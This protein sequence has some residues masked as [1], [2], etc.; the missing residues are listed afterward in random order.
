MTRLLTISSYLGIALFLMLCSDSLVTEAAT[1]SYGNETDRL[2]L[3]H[4]K[5]GISEDPLGALRSWNDTAHFCDWDGVACDRQRQRVTALNLTSLQLTGSISPHVTNLTYLMEL[6]LSHNGFQGMLPQEIGRLSHLQHLDLL[7]NHVTGEIPTG[8]SNCKDL[9][10]LRLRFNHFTGGIPSEVSFLP[11]LQVL[12]LFSNNLTGTIPPSLGNLSSLIHLSVAI[13][14]IEGSFPA[15]IG[16]LSNLKRLGFHGNYISGTIPSE[17]LNLSSLELFLFAQNNLHGSLPSDVGVAL[18]KLQQF[19]GGLNQFTGPIPASL[20][21]ASDLQVFD[22]AINQLSGP[23]PVTFGALHRLVRLNFGSNNLEV[24]KDDGM[25]FITTL[26]NCSSLEVFAFDSNLLSGVLPHS[27]VNLSSHLNILALGTNQLSG[28]FPIGIEKYV[29]LSL[30]SL[31]SNFFTGQIPM[32]LGRFHL[33]EMLLLYGNEFFGQIPSSLGNLTQLSILNLAGNNFTGS[34]PPTLGNCQGLQV[35]DL[36]N[37]KLNGTVPASIL[38]ISSLSISLNLSKN[39]LTGALPDEVQNLQSLGKLDVS[40]NKLSGKI[41]TALGRCIGLESLN[42]GGNYFEGT[43]PLFLSALSGIRDL[44]LSANNLSGPI[45]EFLVKLSSLRNLNL[46]FNSLEGEVPTKGVFGNAS[47]FSIVGNHNLCGGI[48]SLHLPA[49]SAQTYPKHHNRAAEASILAIASTALLLLL[50]ASYFSARHLL[51]RSKRKKV[52]AVSCPATGP[53]HVSYAE[54]LGAAS[55]FSLSKLVGEGSYGSVYKAE[56]ICNEGIVAVKVFRTEGQAHVLDI[57]R[58]ECEAMKNIRHRNLVKIITSCSSVDFRGRDFKA[59]VYEHMPNGNLD[60]WLHPV[61]S[62]RKLMLTERLNIAIDVASALE[63]LHLHCYIPIVHCNLKP[64]NVLLNSDMTAHLGDF[65]LARFLPNDCLQDQISS[66]RAKG[67]A[68]YL[69]PEY[70]KGG[71]ASTS[72]DVYSYGILLLEIFTGKKPTDPMFMDGLTLHRFACSAFP[73]RVTEVIDPT[74]VPQEQEA[75]EFDG[76]NMKGD[77]HADGRVLDC[78]VSVIKIAIS[79]SKETPSER[80]NM[81]Q[82]SRQLRMVRDSFLVVC[83]HGLKQKALLD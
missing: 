78:L 61:Q 17:L 25:S 16:R 81:Q 79:C 69:A 28:T 23:I 22:F 54:L 41:P 47:A 42:L 5:D 36:S 3:L 52:P 46:S 71:G 26:T 6:D 8:L 15:D 70:V 72:G 67:S 53:V 83:I 30:L 39:H 56:N 13:N 4:F 33:L 66:S 60:S 63:Y 64:S 29:N 10:F 11:K 35:L 12:D 74:L 37:N 18:P 9:Q 59:I 27:I 75:C 7:E 80:I 68:G 43:I 48:S 31:E 32:A 73:D 57:F 1:T 50:V 44:D 2:S 38:K 34:V 77:G 21:N 40:E 65:G 14:G 45:P 24:A 58:C 20:S 49:C 76:I 19:A 55:E 62:D 82:V 51:E